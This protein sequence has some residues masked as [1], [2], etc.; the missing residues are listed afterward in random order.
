MEAFIQIGI[1]L[2]SCAA[3]WLL[4]QKKP[5]ARWGYIVGIVGQPC[6]FYTTWEHAQWGMF[7]VTCWFTFSYGQGI[8]NYWTKPSLGGTSF[9]CFL[10]GH[11]MSYAEPGNVRSAASCVREGCNYARPG[12]KWPTCPEEEEL[13][14]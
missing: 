2:F 1:T 5:W 7:L 10:F 4:A 11:W 9:V 13:G 14:I 12:T 8:W 6:W 3:I